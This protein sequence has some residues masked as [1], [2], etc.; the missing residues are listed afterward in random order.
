[1]PV[2]KMQTPAQAKITTPPIIAA[3]I[4]KKE[5]V[6]TKEPVDDS[7]LSSHWKKTHKDDIEG[8]YKGL[9]DMGMQDIGGLT[10]ETTVAGSLE[11]P[12][13]EFD[14]KRQA[15]PGEA[16]T[17]PS[18]AKKSGKLQMMNSLDEMFDEGYKQ[19]YKTAGQFGAA[20]DNL[21]NSSPSARAWFGDEKVRKNFPNVKQVAAAK[22]EE[23][24]KSKEAES[25]PKA[26][27]N[28]QSMQSKP[29]VKLSV[30]NK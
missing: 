23:L 9:R 8:Q 25:K 18:G 5:P 20:F 7:R 2:T 30:K 10:S 22:F 28:M 24:V 19:N 27:E 26:T 1:M 21:I 17:L 6:I 13:L 3:K 11:A 15:K 4:I 16:V 12:K 14:K 29:A